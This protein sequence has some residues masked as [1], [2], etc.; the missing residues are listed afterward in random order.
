[1]SALF[2]AA[3]HADLDDVAA[4]LA[5]AFAEDPPTR[6]VFD[7]P[8]VLPGF[9][10][11]VAG[12]VLDAG[13]IV[14]ILPATA[15]WIAVPH[16]LPPPEHPALGR[17]GEMQRLLGERHP[18]PPHHYLLFYGVRPDRQSAGLGGHILTR[19]TAR[20]DRDR[21]AAYTEASTWRGAQLKL[22]HGFHLLDALQLP[23]GPEIYPAWRDPITHESQ[24]QSTLGR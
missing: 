12:D 2:A 13:G 8:S 6:W 7:D 5:A 3:T 17:A 11:T 18:E 1:M 10:R 15:A 14:E 20:A 24:R 9:F 19:L 22:R 16:G 4:V 21:V 23:G